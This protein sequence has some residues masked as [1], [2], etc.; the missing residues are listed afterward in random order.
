MKIIMLCYPLAIIVV[1]KNGQNVN[2]A[3]L[4]V[5]SF[6]SPL[7]QGT[8]IFLPTISQVP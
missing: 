3:R 2:F 5:F 1:V 4:S 6:S 7:R 8:L